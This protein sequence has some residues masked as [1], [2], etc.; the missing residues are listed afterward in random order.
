MP[1]SRV[2]VP[3]FPPIKSTSYGGA[4][5]TPLHRKRKNRLI[6]EFGD[7]LSPL[8]GSEVRIAQRHRDRAVAEEVADGV[9]RHATLNQA[10]GEV[11]PEVMPPESGDL[12]AL[13]GVRP[14]RLESR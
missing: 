14:R 12:R 9:Q 5:K 3:P 1:G 6:V 7:G 8:V 4:F 10:R 11:V 2:R 13:E